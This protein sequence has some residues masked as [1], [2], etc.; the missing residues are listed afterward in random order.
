M[1]Q[2][3]Q[4]FN[5]RIQEL[6]DRRVDPETD[7]LLCAHGTV[8]SSCY[9]SLMA[10]SI[11]HTE[12]LNDSDSMKMKLSNLELHEFA[13][14][15]RR[16]PDSYRLF[17]IA[18]SIAA[19]LLLFVALSTERFANYG[20]T[21][22]IAMPGENVA[23][24]PDLSEFPSANP[25]SLVQ[26]RESLNQIDFYAYSSELPGVRPFKALSQCFDWLQS[27]WLNRNRDEITEPDLGRLNF[28]NT[29]FRGTD[30]LAFAAMA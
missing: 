22:G 4:Q 14:R 27:S 10:Y 16:Q 20:R 6:M 30:H 23:I 25:I 13:I 28:P 21:N 8:C 11:L 3:C 19:M 7:D 1:I 18:T 26:F 12:F 9:E 5:E 29:D 15:N 17:A 2:N 24:S